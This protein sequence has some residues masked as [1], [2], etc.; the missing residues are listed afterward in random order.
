MYAVDCGAA[1]WIGISTLG[2][3]A[4]GAGHVSSAAASIGCAAMVAEAN[5]PSKS[6]I[7]P[8]SRAVTAVGSGTRGA[9]LSLWRC[10]L[11]ALSKESILALRPVRVETAFFARLGRKQATTV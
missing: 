9:T 3:L 2:D 4:L 7:G 10:S 8:S 6:C 5:Q 1:F 11:G